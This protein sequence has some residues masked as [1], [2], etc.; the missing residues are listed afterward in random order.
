MMFYGASAAFLLYNIVEDSK[1]PQT[2]KQVVEEINLGVL[3]MAILVKGIEKLMSLGVGK[4]LQGFAERNNGIFAEFAGNLAEW[5]GEGGRV[6]PVGRMGEAFVAVFGENVAEFM[7]RRIGPAMA[8]AGLVLSAFILYDAIKSGDV[9]SIIFEAINTFLALASVVLI[10][11]ELL[12]VAWA[13][14]V[15]LAVAAI[16][17]IVLLIQLIWN[18]IDPPKPP[19]DPITEFVSGPM[20]TQGFAHP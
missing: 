6:V 12:S 4:A 3:A 14:P 8:V 7:A 11:L 15:G 13:G 10:G 16:G 18:W 5:F 17:V 1:Q 19:A 2:P 20:V 9:R